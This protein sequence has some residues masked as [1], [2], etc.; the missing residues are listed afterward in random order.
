MKKQ[1]IFLV[2][3]AFISSFCYSAEYFREKWFDYP[4]P[5][6]IPR[7]TA[8]CVQ[9]GSM[10]VPCPTWSEPLRMCL[11]SACTGHA[12]TTDVLRV[13]PTFVVNGPDSVDEAT[14]NA[15]TGIVA[16]CVVQAISAAK[17]AAAITP[18]PEPVARV[19]AGLASGATYFK[20]CI[21]TVNAVA[22]VAGIV[23]QLQFTVE[24]PTH[25]API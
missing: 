24:T 11:K 6:T 13:T 1:I 12:Y 17:G 25:W 5:T 3:F 20:A 8:T 15:V 4:D 23:N 14:R 10:H 16:A 22:V 7:T 18:S 19:G 9:Q 2:F 21:S